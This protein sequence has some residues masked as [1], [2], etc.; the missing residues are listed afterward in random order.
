MLIN[1]EKCVKIS[2]ELTK[3]SFDLIICDEGH[4]L[5]SQANKSAKAI[6]SLQTPRRILLTGTPIQN[7]LG[8]FFT[9][10]D[11]VNPGL[12]N[13]YASFKKVYEMPIVKA[14]QPGVGRKAVELGKG[15]SEELSKVTGMFVLRRTSEI[16]EKY[17]PLKRITP[18]ICLVNRIDEYV[19]FCAPTT[20]QQRVY[21]AL[22]ESQAF[23]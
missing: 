5:K 16:L 13:T 17:L 11:F 1:Y 23:Q 9:M 18:E 3:M 4:R 15:R 7:D 6:K 8:E 10:V 19:V 22:L 21:K 2:S 14:R 12:L 20:L